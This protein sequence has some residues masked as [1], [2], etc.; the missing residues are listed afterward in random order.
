MGRRN[1]MKEAAAYGRQVAGA[2]DLNPELARLRSGVV[3]DAA[4]YKIKGTRPGERP[5]PLLLALL[6]RQGGA[7]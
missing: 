3:V 1:S 6:A 5:R 2:R 4:T 7:K